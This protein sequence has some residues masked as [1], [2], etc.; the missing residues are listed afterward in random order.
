MPNRDVDAAASAM[1]RV[2]EDFNLWKKLGNNGPAVAARKFSIFEGS[3][4]LS[5]IYER[6]SSRNQSTGQ[7]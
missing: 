6:V 7:L 5:G 3:R 1:L 2:V 4:K